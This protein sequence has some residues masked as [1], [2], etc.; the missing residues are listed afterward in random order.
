VT[1]VPVDPDNG[2][3]LVDLPP[4]VP[5]EAFEAAYLAYAP[6]DGIVLAPAELCLLKPGDEIEVGTNSLAFVDDV[7][8]GIVDESGTQI[9][10]YQATGDV[11]RFVPGV[12]WWQAGKP[13]FGLLPSNRRPRR[14]MDTDYRYDERVVEVRVDDPEP[15]F[16]LPGYVLVR[17]GTYSVQVMFRDASGFFAMDRVVAAVTDG[18]LLS[19]VSAYFLPGNTGVVATFTISK[20][21]GSGML[22]VLGVSPLVFDRYAKVQVT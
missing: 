6:N 12:G 3:P 9:V 11:S 18:L 7:G 13:V 14:P 16:R 5:L 19:D 17:G 20:T 4:I 1:S 21:S 15:R 22:H 10:F 8:N 2:Q